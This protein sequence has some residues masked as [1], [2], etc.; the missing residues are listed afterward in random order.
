MTLPDL[1][2]HA[3]WSTAPQ[4]RW[5]AVA[6]RTSG[7]YRVHPPE[8][9]GALERFWRRLSARAPGGRL[10]AGFDF[11][12]GVPVAYARRAGITDFREALP[13]FGTGE[14][15]A[16]Y[17]LAE[18]P[19]EISLHRPFYPRRPGGTTR[20][21]LTEA[22]GVSAFS[23]LLRR[24]DQPTA[25]R[26]AAGSLFWTMG[27]QQSGRAAIAGW[28]GL[29]A[30]ALRRSP[31]ALRLWPFDGGLDALLAQPGIVVAEAYPAEAA[32]HIGLPAYG[33]GWS[34]RVQADRRTHAPALMAWAGRR[35]VRLSPEMERA[36]TSGFGDGVH[37][38]DR[39]D[40]AVGL[41]GMLEVALGHRR[42][43]APESEAVR[44]V[45][46]WMLGL[47]AGLAG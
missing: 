19:E 11:P 29:L 16:F 34:K 30:P 24:C 27:A 15:H 32:L 7:A 9:V 44:R 41:F 18:R 2:V 37:G 38:E 33:R 23:E 26:R 1:V 45:E 43:G 21:H 4:K 42:A 3:D 22:L 35:G 39:F 46:G 6:T 8:H 47:D 28:Q 20:A 12:I 5:M 17:D 14:W 25:A 10:L 36:V 40:A 13:A 31:G